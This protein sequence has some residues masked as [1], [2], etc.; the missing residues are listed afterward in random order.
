M[1]IMYFFVNLLI[2]IN[3]YIKVPN[4]DHF[5]TPNELCSYDDMATTIVVDS[6]MQFQ[7]HKMNQR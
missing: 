6:I 1:Q 7:T 2:F 4:G 3:K 5:L